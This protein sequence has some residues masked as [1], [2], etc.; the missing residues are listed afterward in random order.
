MPGELNPRGLQTFPALRPD[1]RQIYAS[2]SAR[3]PQHDQDVI[4]MNEARHC[5]SGEVQRAVVRVISMI[6]DPGHPAGDASDPPK[7]ETTMFKTISA[8][9][10]AV[11]VLAAPVLAA[12]PGKAIQAPVTKSAQAP[13]IKADT[14]KSKFLNANARMGRHHHEHMR[15]HRHHKHMGALKTHAAPK[16]AVKHVTPAPK[17]G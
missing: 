14:A 9:L 13:V 11:S 15:H 4:Q 10:V 12:T 2:S 17:R 5:A 6:S 8:A 16:L 7:E 1:F 3:N